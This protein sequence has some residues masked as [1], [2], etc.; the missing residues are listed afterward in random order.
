[1]CLSRG[2]ASSLAYGLRSAPASVFLGLIAKM[3]AIQVSNIQTVTK[4]PHHL[5]SA[6]TRRTSICSD[7]STA[8]QPNSISH[9]KQSFMQSHKVV[10]QASQA[11]RVTKLPLADEAVLS[12]KLG[13]IVKLEIQQVERCNAPPH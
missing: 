3:G 9:I 13:Y 10:T 4:V 7:L 5:N 12:Q 2:Q 8:G 11:P 1:M 6:C